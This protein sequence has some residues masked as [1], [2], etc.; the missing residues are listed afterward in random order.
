VGESILL[1]GRKLLQ[2]GGLPTETWGTS[3]LGWKESFQPP[4]LNW[5]CFQI[6][7]DFQ[8]PK[9]VL[10]GVF[11]EQRDSEGIFVRGT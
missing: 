11:M 1:R 9:K 10:E 4:G 3:L 5:A 8:S 6:S 7:R 2:G